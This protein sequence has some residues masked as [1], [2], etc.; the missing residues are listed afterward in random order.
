MAIKRPIVASIAHRTWC[1]DEYGMAAMFLLE[2]DEHALLIDT[3]VGLTDIPALVRTLS[4][5]P[6]TVALTH[7]HV[8][9]AGGLDQLGEAFI[10]P[11]DRELALSVS[12]DDR[13][14]FV[15]WLLSLSEGIYDVGPEDLRLGK[16]KARLLPLTGGHVFHLGGRD[17][18]VIGTPGHTPGGLS[19]L[20]RKERILFSGD[21]CNPNT[22]LAWGQEEAARLRPGSSVGDLLAAAEALEARHADYDRHFTGHIGFAADVAVLPAPEELIRECIALCR[23]LLSGRAAGVAADPGNPADSRLIAETRTMRICYC[24]DQLR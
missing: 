11:A 12:P 15:R 24:P 7:G 13:A 4:D 17:V 6:L 9:H 22:L 14:G 21:A 8:D 1:I 23:D 18:E 3:G 2:G 5:K 16:E 10:H 20:D 19:Y